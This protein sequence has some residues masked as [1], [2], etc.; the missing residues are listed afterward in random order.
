[1]HLFAAHMKLQIIA[2]LMASHHLHFSRLPHNHSVSLRVVFQQAPRH[3]RRTKQPDLLIAREGKLQRA[4][5]VERVG[6]HHGSHRQSHKPLHIAGAAPIEAAIFFNHLPRICAPVLP[7]HR[8]NIGMA[9]K[10]HTA[11]HIRPNLRHQSGFIAVLT[12]KDHAVNSMLREI[13]THKVN[14]RQ[15]RV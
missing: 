12:G 7:F 13:I 6:L 14:E 1:M 11:R 4:F 10:R 8:H 3:I 2:A 5:E 9:R 15:V